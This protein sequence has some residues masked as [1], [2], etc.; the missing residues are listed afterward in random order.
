MYLVDTSVWIHALRPHG[1]AAMQ[2]Q[3]RTLVLSGETAVTDWIILELMTGLSRSEDG[4]QLLER[5]SPVAR[6]PFRHEWWIKAW[7]LAA[8][9]QKQGISPS[10]AECLIATVALESS[11]SLI[12]C[13]ADFEAICLHSKLQTLDWTI[14]L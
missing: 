2:L 10:A 3:L 1:N 6:I 12:H 9:L 11:V 8:G 5:F 4:E 7:E 14:Y 13:D